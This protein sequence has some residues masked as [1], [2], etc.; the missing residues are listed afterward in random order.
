MLR[1]SDGRVCWFNGANCVR[2]F[3]E[4]MGEALFDAV[5]FCDD[6]I[7]LCLIRAYYRVAIYRLFFL[8]TLMI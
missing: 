8:T 3:G 5:L 2:V 6:R 1:A 7:I 4:G